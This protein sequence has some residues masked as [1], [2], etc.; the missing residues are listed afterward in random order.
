MVIEMIDSGDNL[1]GET[2]RNDDSWYGE[3]T[4]TGKHEKVS[5]SEMTKPRRHVLY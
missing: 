5:K 2:R 1:T 3:E 4:A